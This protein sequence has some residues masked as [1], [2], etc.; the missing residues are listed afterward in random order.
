MNTY[1]Q[2]KQVLEKK[3]QKK[4]LKKKRK[5]GMDRALPGAGGGSSK[6]EW[7]I[8]WVDVVICNTKEKKR[9][10]QQSCTL[11]QMPRNFL[12]FIQVDWEGKVFISVPR[13]LAA[14]ASV[15]ATMMVSAPMTS[16]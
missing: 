11:S 14:S 12:V 2:L 15:L 4:K 1:K 6:D 10:F 16:A 9:V 7:M 5:N 13:R 8:T 3:S